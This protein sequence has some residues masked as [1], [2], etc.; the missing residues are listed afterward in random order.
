MDLVAKQL[1]AAGTI[2]AATDP[3]LATSECRG[4]AI[5]RTGAGIYTVTINPGVAGPSGWPS[6]KEL[7]VKVQ[8]RTATII[9]QAVRTS[10]TVITINTTDAATGAATE[11][12]L[13]FEIAGL[14]TAT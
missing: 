14:E 4:C 2:L 5:G 1:Y 3:T 13:D 12:D 7:L 6:A 8:A 9:A 11:A 10:N